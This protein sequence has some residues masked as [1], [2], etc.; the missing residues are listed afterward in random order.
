MDENREEELRYIQ[1]ILDKERSTIEGQ[2][3][4]IADIHQKAELI[5][6]INLIKFSQ[7]LLRRCY[8]YNISPRAV[9]RKVPITLDLSSDYRL[10]DDVATENRKY[11]QE[12]PDFRLKGGEIIIG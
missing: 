8:E 11:W 6:K 2:L 5:G 12:L 10:M 7:A 3:K 1:G 4:A 9:W